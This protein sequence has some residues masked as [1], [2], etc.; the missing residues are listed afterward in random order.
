MSLLLLLSLMISCGSNSTVSL[1]VT[2]IPGSPTSTPTGNPSVITATP[3]MT[4]TVT[5]AQSTPTHTP[6]T[7]TPVP[8]PVINSIRDN[9]G[10]GDNK[11]PENGNSDVN[12]SV[13]G[14]H[15]SGTGVNVTFTDVLSG[16]A[17]TATVNSLNYGEIKGTINIPGGRYLIEV[18]LGGKTSADVLYFY[19]GAGNYMITVE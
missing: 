19:K 18:R 4:S 1:S 13:F 11:D 15:L 12:F 6:S 9:N 7:P 5:P 17:Y 2:P 16:T 8:T 10:T 14:Y 3:T